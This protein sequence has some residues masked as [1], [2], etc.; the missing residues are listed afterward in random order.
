MSSV[1]QL[2]KEASRGNDGNNN[3]HFN[4]NKEIGNA[5]WAVDLGGMRRR[6]TRVRITYG[7]DNYQGMHSASE[8][9]LHTPI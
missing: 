8:M 6:V 7:K 2:T 1:G 5:W 3:T 9:E 4:T